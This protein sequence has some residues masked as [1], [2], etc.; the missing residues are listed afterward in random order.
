MLQNINP[1]LINQELLKS[2]IEALEGGY[3]ETIINLIKWPEFIKACEVDI[4]V[5]WISDERK[6]AL[7]KALAQH[8]TNEVTNQQAIEQLNTIIV[9]ARKF[10]TK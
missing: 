7:E 2:Q 5:E 6:A 8:K 10:L 3:V 1:A 9:E 4:A